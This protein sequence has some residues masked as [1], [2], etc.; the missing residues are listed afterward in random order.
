MMIKL[1][2]VANLAYNI[3][4]QVD[5]ADLNGDWPMDDSMVSARVQSK[6]VDALIEQTVK[7]PKKGQAEEE[8]DPIKL[9]WPERAEKPLSEKAEG[10]YSMAY[11][12]LFPTGAGD[13]NQTN[14]K[15]RNP[16]SFREWINHCLNWH[17]GRFRK[18]SDFM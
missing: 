14:W 8:K 3:L 6:T 7:G 17:D 15:S 11:P 4:Y 9:A 13:F 12:K 2:L 5:E 16:P 1:L 10:F 18:D